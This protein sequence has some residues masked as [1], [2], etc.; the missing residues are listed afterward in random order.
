[1]FGNFQLAV[2]VALRLFFADSVVGD[3]GAVYILLL[4][5]VQAVTIALA[6]VGPLY[7]MNLQ[8]R[9]LLRTEPA[10]PQG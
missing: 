4:Y 3:Q 5:L 10:A 7:G 2:S 9:D 1:M 8:F 6:G